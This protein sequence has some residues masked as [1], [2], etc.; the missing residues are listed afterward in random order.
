MRK[1]GLTRGSPNLV[2]LCLRKVVSLRKI[3]FLQKERSVRPWGFIA[4]GPAVSNVDFVHASGGHWSFIYE[5][6]V[7]VGLKEKIISESPDA[8]TWKLVVGDYC[9][10]RLT[11]AMTSPAIALTLG[12]NSTSGQP[13]LVAP[14]SCPSCLLLLETL[15]SPKP[16]QPESN[17]NC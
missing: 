12:P 8:D 5:K 13:S 11:P 1:S 3:K 17:L 15:F 2:I 7:A 9:S 4:E 6:L 10:A 14:T 16:S